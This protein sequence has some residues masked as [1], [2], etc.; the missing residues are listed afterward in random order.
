MPRYRI[1]VN[2]VVEADSEEE[3]CEQVS[4]DLPNVAHIEEMDESDD[5][6]HLE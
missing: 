3:A 2:T 6:C 4:F 1:Q 5:A